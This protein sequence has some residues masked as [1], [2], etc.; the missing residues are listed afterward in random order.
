M[1]EY[2]FNDWFE[3]TYGGFLRKKEYFTPCLNA[4]EYQQK[5]IDSLKAELKES[6][7]LINNLWEN[8]PEK[9]K[10]LDMIQEFLKARS[11]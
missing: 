9:T 2:S 4:W 3:E 6:N 10:M 11:E 8:E 5:E 7:N 1:R